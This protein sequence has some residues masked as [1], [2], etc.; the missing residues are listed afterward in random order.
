MVGEGE[1]SLFSVWDADREDGV[2]AAL[3][4]PGDGCSWAWGL[5]GGDLGVSVVAA[6]D[7][8]GIEVGV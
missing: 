6:E 7:V 4:G 5:F 8:A 2:G 1:D 3:V